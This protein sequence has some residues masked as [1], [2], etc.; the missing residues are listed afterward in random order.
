MCVVVY[1]VISNYILYVFR[2]AIVLFGVGFILH[3]K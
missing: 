2:Y 1:G 3:L